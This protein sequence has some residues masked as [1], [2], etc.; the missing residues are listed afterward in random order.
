MGAGAAELTT[1]RRML[2]ALFLLGS[3]GTAAELVLMEHTEG[4]WQNVPLALIAIGCIGLAAVALKRG[5]V[6]LRAF[7]LI[8]GL[9]VASGV[10][11]ILLHYQGNTEFEL[12]LNPDAAGIELF[13]ESMKGATPA[14]APGTMI[15]LGAVG[16]GY[17]YLIEPE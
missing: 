4:V 13:W 15:L 9:F 3:I 2:A 12:E 7:Q 14:L 17:A 8:L 1:I 16:L 5:G 11:G 6:Q 10:A